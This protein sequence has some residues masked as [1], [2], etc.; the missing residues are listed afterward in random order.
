MEIS[1]VYVLLYEERKAEGKRNKAHEV[2]AVYSAWSSGSNYT[3]HHW[4]DNCDN[5]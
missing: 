5:K 1:G 2:K 4:Q 3:A